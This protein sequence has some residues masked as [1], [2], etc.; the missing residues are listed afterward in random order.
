MR[1]NSKRLAP[2]NSVEDEEFTRIVCEKVK[3]AIKDLLEKISLAV[4]AA[5]KEQLAPALKLALSEITQ[6]PQQQTPMREE[7]LVDDEQNAD[8]PNIWPPRILPLSGKNDWFLD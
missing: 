3:I 8:N 4:G 6:Q 5:I 2:P 1:R 7:H